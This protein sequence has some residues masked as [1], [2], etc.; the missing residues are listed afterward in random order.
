[1]AKKR[2]DKKPA[3]DNEFREKV[4]RDIALLRQE[5]DQIKNQPAG[6]QF[7]QGV[8]AGYR[9]LPRHVEGPLRWGFIGAWGRGGESCEVDV[10]TTTEK[11]FFE[12]PN[13]SDEKVAEFA[14][15]FTKPHTVRICK[16]LF[17]NNGAPRDKIINDCGLSGRELD[18][19]VKPLINGHFVAWHG[20]RLK[21]TNHN[22]VLTLM[23]MT[24]S[25]N[26]PEHWQDNWP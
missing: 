12:Y 25:A 22:Y 23:S 5:V 8:I 4:M 26:D 14:R 20:D 16:Y 10:I 19:A 2:I 1:M 11:E 7:P 18:A 24:W 13:T 21:R 17:R 3:S 15:T 9:E 6:N